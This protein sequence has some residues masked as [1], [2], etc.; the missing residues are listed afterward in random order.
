MDTL[1]ER[2]ERQNL[3]E[4]LEFVAKKN[5]E[6]SATKAE[7]DEQIADMM[8]HYNSDNEEL[9]MA[10]VVAT[11]MQKSQGSVLHALSR[12][13]DSPYFGR[14]DFRADDE[15]HISRIYIGRGGLYDERTHKTVV[16]DWRTPVA[17]L[18]YDATPGRASYRSVEETIQGE[19][20][21]KRTYNIKNG[22]LGA[23][24]DADMV[25]NDA[26]LQEYLS[27]NA[28]AVLKDI[29]A[30]IQKDQ[31]EI[32]RV[33]PWKDVLVQGVAGSGK[34]TVALHRLAYLIFNFSDKMKTSGFVVIGSNRMF[35]SY[36]S[37]ML[38]DL[39]VENVRQMVMPELLRYILR[40]P[41]PERE[42]TPP[43]AETAWQSSQGFFD[44]FDAHVR[45]FEDSV[46]LS[47]D[48][49]LLDEPIM[50]RQEIAERVIGGRTHPCADRAE[51]MHSIL[52]LRL[53]TALPRTIARLE[54]QSDRDVARFR[55]GEATGYSNVGDIIDYRNALIAVAKK[56]SS[57][58]RN[59]FARK[60]RAMPPEKLYT[61]FLTQSA[62]SGDP[63]A[64]AVLKRVRAGQYGVYDLCA[65]L[66][67]AARLDRPTRAD[68]FRHLVIDEAQDFGPS[69]YAMFARIFPQPHTTFTILGDVSQNLSGESGVSD[70]D[71]V[72]EASFAGRSHAFRV[73]SKSYRNTIEIAAVANAV[74]SH[75]RARAYDITP[76]VRHGE[77]VI[78]S[79][80]DDD[81]A[82]TAAIS[83]ELTAWKGAEG[84]L[85]VVCATAESARALYAA[86]PAREGVHL[87]T[88]D[89]SLD[90]TYAGGA[91]V[92]DVKSVK[93]LEF[94]R[95]ILADADAASYPDTQDA[96]RA[97]YVA[98]TRALHT[99]RILYSGK[100]SPLFTGLQ[101]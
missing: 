45:A 34:T 29:V 86:L 51:L 81:G 88:E 1:S 31:N 99:L 44:A 32:I 33:D 20:S 9:R 69:L 21:C 12:A 38:P 92:F 55:A 61:Q 72:L 5:A 58:L 67:A 24:F 3:K 56:Q 87:F 89:A 75:S 85:A 71:A 19:L 60:V 8:E 53:S 48:L 18:Y 83:E 96:V 74:L 28:S 73:L 41:E 95:V 52:E 16:V 68:E 47:E 77:P 6:V 11:D 63:R 42:S 37:G 80:L 13:G 49:M 65:L 59:R 76:V 90:G 82:V 57:E 54:A 10:L 97:L 36:I 70:W 100:P 30:T 50:T 78:F 7:L 66:Y 84:S 98:C 93:G 26:L 15:G 40:L 2:F 23:Y 64:K 17:N 43:A 62:K 91:S 25:A 39:G 4:T 22:V 27:K 46:F 35:L 79:A 94:D 14:V 101:P